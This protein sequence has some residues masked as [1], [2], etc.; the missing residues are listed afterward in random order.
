MGLA[1]RE[2]EMEESKID[3]SLREDPITPSFNPRLVLTKCLY[4]EI[5]D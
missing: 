3:E 2:R 1:V 4:I 5:V